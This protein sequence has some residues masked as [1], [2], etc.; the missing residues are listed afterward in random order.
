MMAFV[1]NGVNETTL[2]AA[3]KLTAN[4]IAELRS[5]LRDD[6]HGICLIIRLLQRRSGAQSQMARR[7]PGVDTML[8]NRFEVRRFVSGLLSELHAILSNPQLHT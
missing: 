7:C 2:K 4:D 8:H 1:L 6:R 3:L 5:L